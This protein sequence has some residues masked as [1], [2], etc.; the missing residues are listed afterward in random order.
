[1]IRGL[2]QRLTR[3][4]LSAAERQA[5]AD[6]ATIAR[7]VESL[8]YETLM[9][10]RVNP[11]SE[12]VRVLAEESTRLNWLYPEGNAAADAAAGHMESRINVAENAYV[13]HAWTHIEFYGPLF[14]VNCAAFAIAAR[15][16]ISAGDYALLTAPWREVFGP[17]PG[18]EGGQFVQNFE[19][20]ED[21]R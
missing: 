7:M 9:G 21:P 16:R 11:G 2:Y 13:E 19:P 18:E 20:R 4:P 6:A 17:L 1:M 3:P 5:I 14:A 8:P 15:H 10:L 12:P